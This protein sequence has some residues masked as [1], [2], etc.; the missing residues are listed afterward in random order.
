MQTSPE[1]RNPPPDPAKIAAENTAIAW[2][3]LEAITH[4]DPAGRGLSSFRRASVPLD[5]GQL[6]AA[7]LHLAEH[8]RS[9]GIVTGFCVATS[10]GITVE[11]DGPPG[12]LFLARALLAL[13]V[14]VSLIGD[15]Y[16][17]PLLTCG[18]EMWNIDR[19]VRSEE[20][21]SELQSH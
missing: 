16:A 13:G 21:T 7:A 17:L 8:A 18:C 15:C 5:A 6:Q 11:T 4:V 3:A 2:S 1:R 20:H 12:A 14:D 19:G 10:D 9:V